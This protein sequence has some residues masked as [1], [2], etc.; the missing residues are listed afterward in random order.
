MTVH[1]PTEHLSTL[2]FA[3]HATVEIQGDTAHLQLDGMHYT[4]D[5]E[6]VTR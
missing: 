4:A 3:M 1:I 6:P 5:L 2:A